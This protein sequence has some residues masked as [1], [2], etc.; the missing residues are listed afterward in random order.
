ML[1]ACDM[2]VANVTARRSVVA[3]QRGSRKGA[4]GEQRRW[5]PRC[6]AR[7]RRYLATTSLV[8]CRAAPRGDRMPTLVGQVLQTEHRPAEV[9]ALLW[10]TF[11]KPTSRS[12]SKSLKW[13]QAPGVNRVER[14]ADEIR[15]RGRL[16]VVATS[17]FA[18][19]GIP[20][21]RIEHPLNLLVHRNH[22]NGPA[23]PRSRHV[24]LGGAD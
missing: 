9:G 8:C 10:R 16:S 12:S 13:S 3:C 6:S 18:A 11:R 14:A 22:Y 24:L 1:R 15:R 19:R 4:I 23:T 20:T 7:E 17:L 2:A 5:S 21:K